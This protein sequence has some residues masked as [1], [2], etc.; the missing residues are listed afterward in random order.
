MH[1]KLLRNVEG[2]IMAAFVGV[3]LQI[4]MIIKRRQVTEENVSRLLLL[5]FKCLDGGQ[6]IGGDVGLPTATWP[7]PKLA[8]TPPPPPLMLLRRRS[9][10]LQLTSLGWPGGGESAD[11]KW[12]S[13]ASAKQTVKLEYFH[14]IGSLLLVCRRR[15]LAA[16]LANWTGKAGRSH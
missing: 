9:V 15:C 7:S 4:I 10:S 14:N 1:W 12:A 5:V 13:S 8:A 11:N 2:A 6:S 3:L 16:Y